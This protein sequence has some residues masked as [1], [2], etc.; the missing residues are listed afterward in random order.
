MASFI[1]NYPPP[2]NWEK[3]FTSGGHCY[4]HNTVTGSKSVAL[5]SQW[6]FDIDGRRLPNGWTRQRDPISRKVTY[7]DAVT[8]AE[9]YRSPVSQG[10][11]TEDY[12]CGQAKASA[13]DYQF[14]ESD[15]N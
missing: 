13:Q 7:F 6:D 9:Q 10:E 2:T 1:T 5:P 4:Y 11:M 8:K 12:S 14:F 15:Y 3:R